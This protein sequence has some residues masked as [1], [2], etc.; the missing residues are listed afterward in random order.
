MG[1]SEVGHLTLGAGRMVPQDLL[2]IDLAPARRRR[3]S[4][5]RCS[6]PA[7]QHAKRKGATLHLMGLALRR[8]RALAPAPPLRPAR[9]G[10]AAASAARA[11][12][13]S[14]PTAATR[15]RSRLGASSPGSRTPVARRAAGIATVSGRYYAMDRDKRW[16]RVARAYRRWCSPAALSARDAPEERSRPPTTAGRPTSSSSPRSSPPGEPRGPDRRRRRGRLLQLPR[17]PRE[18]A[19]AGAAPKWTSPSS[20]GRGSPEARL[21][22]FT[23]VQAGVRPPGRLLPA[24]R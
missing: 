18:A 11:S 8:R 2:R 15:R 7:M 3:S 6:S 1:N 12:A 23:R 14:S 10:G 16:D 17:R 9:D 19:D 24:S 22:T 21:P 20:R 4:T 13:R 5:T